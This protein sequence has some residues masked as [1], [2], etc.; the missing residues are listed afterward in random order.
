MQ[1]QR[2]ELQK[3]LVS[4]ET[5]LKDLK[6]KFK[7]REQEH[8]EESLRMRHLL[9]EANLRNSSSTA[10]ATSSSSAISSRAG[11]GLR[12]K[13]GSVAQQIAKPISSKVV[14]TAALSSKTIV[15]SNAASNPVLDSQSTEFDFS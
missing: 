10:S 3:K 15:T 6:E 7:Q 12:K 4:I 8:A 2:A 11:G 13:T 9:D 5:E 1:G 14:A